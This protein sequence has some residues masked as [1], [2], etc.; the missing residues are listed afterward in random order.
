M[1]AGKIISNIKEN[2]LVNTTQDAPKGYLLGA[3]ATLGTELPLSRSTT[4]D[5]EGSENEAK[6]LNAL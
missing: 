5:I 3:T 4:A 1:R 6:L 2:R